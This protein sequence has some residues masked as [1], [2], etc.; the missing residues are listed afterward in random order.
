MELDNLKALVE[1]SGMYPVFIGIS[2]GTCSGKTFLASYLYHLLGGERVN[3]ISHDNY[4]KG[5]PNLS[6]EERTRINFDH[7]EALDVALLVEHLAA[8]RRGKKVRIPVYDFKNH[9]R[10]PES[11]EVVPKPFNIVEGI[12]I[13]HESGL[14]NALDLR[15]YLEVSFGTMLRRRLERDVRERGRTV[16]FVRNQLFSTVYPMYM[17]FVEPYKRHAHLVIQEGTTLMERASLVIK[18]ANM[19]VQEM[20][21]IK[22]QTLGEKV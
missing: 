7:P 13:F 9:A 18:A 20:A 5:W 16:D 6:P 21:C 19:P 10:I 4:Y 14:R 11:R 1:G 17:R 3:I 15:V 2:G 8:L 22:P 12:L